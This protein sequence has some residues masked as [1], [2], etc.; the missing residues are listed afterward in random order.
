MKNEPMFEFVA[1][2]FNELP[3]FF[4]SFHGQETLENVIRVSS[5]SGSLKGDFVISFFCASLL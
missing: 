3:M 5:G 1:E 2:K 4:M